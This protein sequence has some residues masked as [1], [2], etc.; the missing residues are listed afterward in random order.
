MPCRFCA[1]NDTEA[2]VDELAAKMW[3][4]CETIDEWSDWTREWEKAG[5][6]WQ[7]MFRNYARV[8]LKAA[9]W[10]CQSD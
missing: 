1:T 3:A 7:G 2:L 6:Y 4:S 9:Q 8:F 5:P 10:D